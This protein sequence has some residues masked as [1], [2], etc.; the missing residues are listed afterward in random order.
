MCILT[1][2]LCGPPFTKKIQPQCFPAITWPRQPLDVSLSRKNRH[3]K[4][5]Q[6]WFDPLF[7]APE[8]YKQC[9]DQSVSLFKF[10][11]SCPQLL[12][13]PIRNFLVYVQIC[14]PEQSNPAGDSRRYPWAYCKST[15]KASNC[16]M[17]NWL[18]YWV[19]RATRIPADTNGET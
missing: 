3:P 8:I 16:L 11:P 9:K 17:D 5:N 10:Q 18:I 12:W 2:A 13:F 4:D 14:S 7:G 19:Y 6:G 1:T 15:W